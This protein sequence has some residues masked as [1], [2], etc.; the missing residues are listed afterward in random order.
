MI[1]VDF[2]GV[3]AD[4][5][6]AWL[7]MYN[8]RYGDFVQESDILSWD[9][10]TYVKPEAKHAIYGIL[11]EPDLYDDVKPI[12]GAIEGL[13]AL[14]KP[15]GIATHCTSEAMV[16]G[17]VAWL[18]RHWDGAGGWPE[19]F[20]PIND[21]SHLR[22]DFLVDDGIHNLAVFQGTGILFNAPHNHGMVPCQRV[23]NW[24]EV[25]AAVT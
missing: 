9:M 3:I 23:M 15:W 19:Y 18:K 7:A 24:S 4:L 6:P 10:A 14:P 1:W 11:D 2:D 25:I 21:K 20:V 5:L 12:D 22:G 16:A 8:T 13:M 17:K